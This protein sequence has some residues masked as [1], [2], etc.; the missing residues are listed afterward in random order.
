MN[1][2]YEIVPKIKRD[3]IQIYQEGGLECHDSVFS[4]RSPQDGIHVPSNAA[5]A[6][7]TKSQLKELPLEF[8]GRGETRGYRFKQ[9]M[10]SDC[11]YIYEV[12]QP[13]P[14]LPPHF[15]IFRRTYNHRF[16]QI[17]Y[18]KSNSFG[19]WALI[20]KDMDSAI[21]RFKSL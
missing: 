9:I 20:A 10:K 15:E 18:P 14:D 1:Q 19:V 4:E 13:Y 5:P 11:A 6:P 2:S 12:R 8:I 3:D 7:M 17:S 16:N 21:R